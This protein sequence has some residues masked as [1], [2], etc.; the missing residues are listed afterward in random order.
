M[1]GRTAARS[2]GLMMVVIPIRGEARAEPMPTEQELPATLRDRIGCGL[3][4]AIGAEVGDLVVTVWCDEEGALDPD[5]EINVR[6]GRAF[7]EGGN[8]A[9]PLSGVVVLTG[10]PDRH[11]NTRGLPARL[12]H[13]LTDRFNRPITGED[14]FSV[15]TGL[16]HP[17]VRRG[18]PTDDATPSRDGDPFP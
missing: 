8:P 18:T 5:A 11:G 4:E 3:F 12:A 1:T 15:F 14:L 16:T 9:L 7:A 17:A 10:G 13:D 6:I 2:A